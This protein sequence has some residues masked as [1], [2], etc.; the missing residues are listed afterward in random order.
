MSDMK[1]YLRMS[2]IT[3]KMAAEDWLLNLNFA[4]CLMSKSTAG[5]LTSFMLSTASYSINNLT[6]IKYII[7][8]N[9]TKNI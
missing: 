3:A 1:T 4:K 6:N 2:G 8:T 7:S 9:T 5:I